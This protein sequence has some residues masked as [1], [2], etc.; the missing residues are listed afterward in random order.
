MGFDTRRKRACVGTGENPLQHRRADEHETHARHVLGAGLGRHTKALECGGT[1]AVCVVDDHDSVTAT[2]GNT[3]LPRVHVTDLDV[4]NRSE[5]IVE[6]PFGFVMARP[7]HHH[8]TMAMS[9]RAFEPHGGFAQ[10]FLS[11]PATQLFKDTIDC[12]RHRL[13]RRGVLE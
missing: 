5:R 13:R 10:N 7:C 8:V 3:L 9:D 2:C 6:K 11:F 12:I 1:R 4:G